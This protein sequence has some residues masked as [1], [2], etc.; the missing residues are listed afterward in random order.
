MGEKYYFLLG[1]ADLEMIEIKK[2][3]DEHGIESANDNLSWDNAYWSEYNDLAKEKVNQGYAVAGVELLGK[4]K[5]P[6][7]KN[8]ID[9]D[10]HNYDRCKPASI[11]QVA[12][13]LG[14][15]LNGWQRKVA[16]NDKAYIPGL[17]NDRTN[18]E[19]IKKIRRNDRDAQRLSEEDFEKA[20]RLLKEKP[21]VHDEKSG[22][23]IWKVD[24]E[25]NS[26]VPLADAFFLSRMDECLKEKSPEECAG[27]LGKIKLIIYNDN[28]F[29]Y[30]GYI[31]A[32]ILEKYQ[33]EI[34]AGQA[35]FGGL[36]PGGYFGF[37]GEFLKN[38]DTET[39]VNEWKTIFMQEKNTIKEREE[40]EMY[41]YHIFLFPFRWDILGKEKANVKNKIKLSEFDRFLPDDW[42]RDAY[43]PGLKPE[44]YN[45]F[46]YF[47]DFVR[48]TI[49]DTNK[50]KKNDSKLLNHYMYQLPNG[51]EYII[52]VKKGKDYR[53]KIDNIYLHVFST[54]VALMSF[55]LKN[56]IYNDLEDILKINEF[57]RRIYPQFLS[58][59]PKKV[60]GAQNIFLADYIELK[61]IEQSKEDFSFYDCIDVGL[62]KFFTLPKFISSLLGKNFTEYYSL[63]C[64]DKIGIRPVVDDRMF[65]ISWYGNDE[66]SGRLKEQVPVKEWHSLSQGI[67]GE[68]IKDYHYRYV[69]DED[70]YKYIFIDVGEPTLQNEEMLEDYLRKHTYARFADKGTF[71]G[72]SR[73]SFVLL[74]DEGWFASNI[75]VTH[76][77]TM[78]YQI[79]VLSLMQRASILRFSD[80]VTEISKIDDERE[81]SERIKILNKEYLIPVV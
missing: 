62:N 51:A 64:Y 28:K 70:W 58:D 19:E 37:T 9:I 59:T 49:F 39:I 42:I 7:N 54:G 46:V 24:N 55:H 21:P 68:T 3:L 10:H 33:Y 6:E 76:L 35:Y 48:D 67:Y 81:Q 5:R 36:P 30:S 50:N 79:I 4:D 78:Y 80:E 47:Y 43:N 60:D 38:K 25:W 18:I 44:Y 11:E 77:K 61:G 12:K 31:P 22:L 73:Y 40:R 2:I 1:G 56:T 74:T 52:S 15:E 57:G 20:K 34:N 72:I 75:L 71:Y 63:E 13:L 65:V 23:L 17:L 69:Q 27:E 41:S 29:N 14:V 53:L 16:I 8:I 66:L 45:E 32:A 26:F